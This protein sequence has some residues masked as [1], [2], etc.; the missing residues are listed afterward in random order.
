ML[1][2]GRVAGG[3]CRKLFTMNTITLP[4]VTVKHIVLPTVL[5]TSSTQCAACWDFY[6]DELI[7]Q[8][9]DHILP[10]SICCY[11]DHELKAYH[12]T[13]NVGAAWPMVG[14]MNAWLGG[15]R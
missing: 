7:A 8:K 15:A 14:R 3:L 1:A 5:P 4:N 12:R 10:V 2:H 6:P 9:P 11:C 13:R